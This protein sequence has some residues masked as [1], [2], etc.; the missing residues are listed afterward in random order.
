VTLRG[1]RIAVIG[2]GNMGEALVRGLLST[3]A[4]GADQITATDVRPARLELFAGSYHVSTTDDNAAAVEG[5]DVVVLAVK[6]Q[7]MSEALASFRGAMSPRKLVVSIAAGVR[8]ARLEQEL[9]GSARVVRVMPNTPS[10]V[11]A[12]AAVL[13]RGLHATESD[14]ATAEAI[15][16]AVGTTARAD[17]DLLDAVTGLSGSGPAYVFLLAEAM[18]RGGIESGLAPEMARKLALQT[19]LGA[20]RLM[21]ES[22]E[23]PG[24]LRQQ[25]TSPAGTTQAALEVMER[26]RLVEVVAEAIQAATRRATELSYS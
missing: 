26:G 1:K 9:G 24:L 8:A 11:G 12:G 21:V 10:R 15:L 22:A 16:A 3:G 4:V 5:S 25:V 2:A 17:E 6:P 7:Q 14:L 18:I 13:S 23:D 19:I 20:A